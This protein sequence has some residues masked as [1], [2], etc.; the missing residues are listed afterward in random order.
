MKNVKPT[1]AKY[2]LL[3]RA[4]GLPLGASLS[5]FDVVKLS[6]VS[7]AVAMLVIPFVF[8]SICKEGVVVLVLIEV[9]DAQLKGV[10]VSVPTTKHAPAEM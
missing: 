1:P 2:S 4:L 9:F 5:G 10:H 8:C 6:E 7:F 3:V